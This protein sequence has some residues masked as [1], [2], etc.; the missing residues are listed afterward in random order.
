MGMVFHLTGW[1]LVFLFLP[2]IELH[3]RGGSFL[4]TEG[5][6]SQCFLLCWPAQ[7]FSLFSD[8]SCYI[9]S[10]R[11][12][13]SVVWAVLTASQGEIGRQKLLEEHH[14]KAE[15]SLERNDCMQR[16]LFSLCLP[17]SLIL[18]DN[19]TLCDL[20][21]DLMPIFL[22][23]LWAFTGK[24]HPLKNLLLFLFFISE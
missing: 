18:Q 2:L 19:P 13:C 8:V 1:K 4:W 22:S 24:E 23:I 5:R 6:H 3:Q 14:K 9:S 7:I 15:P 17:K 12:Q 10:S 11:V 21:F 16:F 20:P